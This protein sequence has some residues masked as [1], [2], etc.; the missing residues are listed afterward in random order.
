M[1]KAELLSLIQVA[2][3][4]RPPDLLV[5][6]AHLVNVYVGEI[7]EGISVGTSG[8]RI[9]FVTS[10]NVMPGENTQVIDAT[11][12]F[13]IPGLIDGHTHLDALHH[14]HE[15]LRYAAT[16]G[17]TTIVTETSGIANMAGIRGVYWL[18]EA[19]RDQPVRV[20]ATAPSMV[21]GDPRV[22]EGR[23]FSPAE[24][25]RLLQEPDVVG[26]GESYWPRVLDGEEEVLEFFATAWN[27][28]KP[29]EGHSSGAKGKKLQG[30]IAAGITS[31]HEP[32]TAQETRERLQLG[33]HV[34]IREGSIRRDLT[35]MAPLAGEGIDTRRL[36]LATDGVEPEELLEKG[37]MEFVVQKAIDLGF[38]PMEA[39]RMAT[40]NVAEHFH[41]DQHLGGIAPGKYA[42]MFLSASLE[43]IKAKT[44]ICNGRIIAADSRLTVP[45]R[46][47]KYPEEAYHIL[48]FPA[49]VTPEFF[50]VSAGPY[51]K[52]AQVRVIRQVSDMLTAE[53]T[54]TLQV[55]GGEVLPDPSRDIIKA[56]AV[57]TIDG[58][59]RFTGFITGFGLKDGA[60]AC[61]YTWD[62]PNVMVVGTNDAD[63]ALAL[64]R[65]RKLGGGLVVA[66]A[67]R[68]VAEL[69]QPICGLISDASLEEISDRLAR[70]VAAVKDMGYP[71][72][73]P[74]LAIQVVTFV[75]VPQ[76]RLTHKGLVSVREKRLVDLLVGGQ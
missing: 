15:Y 18:L 45:V 65:I 70:V 23:N 25:A 10:D 3:G 27:A 4:Q 31:C 71:H 22:Q 11:D 51:K 48:K 56:C 20:L 5:R 66:R 6:N 12:C 41:L 62:V 42:D 30:Y 68:V 19:M 28:G 2:T 64:N 7:Q 32:I 39:I 16:G 26:L 54:A 76:L 59:S 49:G 36:A 33:L 67:G 50:K 73:N 63:M 60:Y 14:I 21:P 29:L 1:N 40:L 47:H 35:A 13:L 44:V 58:S 43:R 52:E 8:S 69:P 24:L 37:Y 74:F 57:S 46:E 9:A 75:G 55:R 53:E 17:T 38:S 34:M 72:S 61:S